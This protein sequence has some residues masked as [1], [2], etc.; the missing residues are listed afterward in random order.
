MKR[1]HFSFFLVLL[2]MQVS[3]LIEAADKEVKQ[4]LNPP[5]DF[6]FVHTGF[7]PRSI[8]RGF[9]NEDPPSLFSCRVNLRNHNL[10]R[11]GVVR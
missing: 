7:E 11:T 5:L 4:V 9:L 8:L 6:E 3:V 1:L 10:S 2:V